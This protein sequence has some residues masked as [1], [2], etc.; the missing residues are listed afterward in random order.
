MYEIREPDESDGLVT[1]LLCLSV[2]LSVSLSQKRLNLILT[3]FIKRDTESASE[4]GK[5]VDVAAP[6]SSNA[7]FWMNIRS[8]RL[9]A[10]TASG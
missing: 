8:S 6:E 4:K 2:C 5:E 9:R 10:F 3:F 7:L 1:G